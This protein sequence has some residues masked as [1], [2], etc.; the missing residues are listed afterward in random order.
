MER[1]LLV[2]F[3]I[4]FVLVTAWPLLFP[5]APLPA[6]SAPVGAEAS[7]APSE[8]EDVQGLDPTPEP[9]VADDAVATEGTLPAETES[10]EYE[11]VV[12]PG[13]RTIVVETDLYKL[14][15][16]TRGARIRSLTLVEYLDGEGRPY[17]FVGQA[18]AEHLDVLPLD[19]ELGDPA[20]TKRAREALY[21][22]DAPGP[23][24]RR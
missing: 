15:L 17:E 5:P 18:V 13:G 9:S 2:F 14:V 12:A 7:T 22:S 10:Q 3:A 4:T 24:H 20:Q 1:R 8:V 6:G 11:V 19:L 21:V 16:D 23:G